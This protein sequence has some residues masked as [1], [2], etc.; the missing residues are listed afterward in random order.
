MND[1][2]VHVPIAG[3]GCIVVEADSQEH[4]IEKVLDETMSSNGIDEYFKGMRGG[5]IEIETLEAYHELTSNPSY[6]KSPIT[7]YFPLDKAKAVL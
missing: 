1:Y 6:K 5:G 4:A 7:L 2:T 3:V